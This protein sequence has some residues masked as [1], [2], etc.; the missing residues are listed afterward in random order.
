MDRATLPHAKSPIP[1]TA[2]QVKSPSSNH[3]EQYLKHIATQT[4]T[5][6]LSAHVR[7]KLHLL[8]LLSIYYTSKFATNTQEIELMELEP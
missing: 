4:V 7:P 5:S 1:H 3:S 8:D 6:R 2:Q